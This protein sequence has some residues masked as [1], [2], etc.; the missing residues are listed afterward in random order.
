MGDRG[1][2]VVTEDGGNKLYLYTHWSGYELPT[3][4]ANALDRARD[5]WDDSPYLA[6][7]LFSEMVRDDINGTTGYGIS[8]YMG[9]GGTE[10]YVN[11]KEQ[12]VTYDGDSW[13]FEDYIA[14]RKSTVGS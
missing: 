13:S 14:A 6:R 3:T 1:N 11:I 5:R 4:V 10:V 8:T 7:V 2:I 12:T 9:D